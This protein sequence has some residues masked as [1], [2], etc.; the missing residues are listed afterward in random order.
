[1]V[2]DNKI[3]V[4]RLEAGEEVYKEIQNAKRVEHCADGGAPH[5]SQEILVKCIREWYVKKQ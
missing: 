5:L 3:A 2:E 4:F 1:M